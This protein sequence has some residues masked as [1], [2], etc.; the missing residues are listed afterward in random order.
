MKIENI[1]DLVVLVYTARTGSLTGAAKV[2]GVTPA[3][4]SAMLK[5]LETQLGTRLFER[6]TRAMRLTEQG[7]TLLEYASR[8]FDLVA[9]GEAQVAAEHT[10]LVGKLRVA[11]PSDLARTT[12]LPWFDE[13]LALHP[14]IEFALAV[15]DRTLNV[16]QDEV[17]IAIRYGNLA[18]SRMVARPLLMQR[19]IVTASPEYL[20]RHG[21][22]MTPLDLTQHNC[23]VFGRGGQEHRL[24]KFSRNGKDMQVRVSGDRCVDDASLAR[25]WAIAGAGFLFKTPLELRPELRAGRL[26]RVLQDWET[27][28]YPL[29]AL[30]PSGRFVP[31]RVR[32]FVAFISDKFS[33]SAFGEHITVPRD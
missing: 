15:G 21:T 24:W 25:E 7:Q 12:L 19:P 5:R 13:F 1:G 8:A 9:E 32:V 33:E 28:P 2:M 11:A 14:A 4:A 26:V 3:A 10:G 31:N 29:Q 18:D 27:D 20:R 17:D 30:L 22:P 6:S 16:I 23:L